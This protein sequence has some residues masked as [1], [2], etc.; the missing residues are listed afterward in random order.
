[1]GVAGL[2]WSNYIEIL[3]QLEICHWPGKMGVELRVA[4]T[5]R[6]IGE[7]ARWRWVDKRIQIV[8]GVK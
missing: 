6:V 2:S 4:R 1:M 8:H 7:K 5:E 3:K